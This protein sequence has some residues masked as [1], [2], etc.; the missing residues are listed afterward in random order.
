VTTKSGLA[1]FKEV[2]SD[3]RS[4]TSWAVGSAV[5]APLA[6]L[7]LK[8]GPPWPTGVPIITALAEL[9][10]LICIFHYWFSAGLKT[11]RRRM[12]ITLLVLCLSFITYFALFSEFTYAPSAL[13]ERQVKGFVLRA[14]VAPVI[15]DQFTTDDALEGAEYKAD[16]VWKAWSITVMRL[17]ILVTWLV[18]FVSLGVFI[19]TFIIAQRRRTIKIPVSARP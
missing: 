1:E 12:L 13:D 2:I 15:N 5:A 7:A 9:L 16:Q 6:D 3:F 8:L 17:T 4:L 10:A 19:G 18:L 14:D 11:H